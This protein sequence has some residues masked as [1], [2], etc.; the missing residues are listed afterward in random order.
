MKSQFSSPALFFTVYCA[1]LQNTT[2]MVIP[3]PS[4]VDP[5]SCLGD[6]MHIGGCSDSLCER[7]S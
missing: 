1:T 6:S 2:T 7:I 4:L 3:A 5:K